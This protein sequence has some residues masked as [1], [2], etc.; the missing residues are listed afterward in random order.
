M[1]LFE[2]YGEEYPIMPCNSIGTHPGGIAF[3]L[4]S[5]SGVSKVWSSGAQKI[6]CGAQQFSFGAVR[7]DIV[8]RWHYHIISN[9]KHLE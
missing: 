9:N 2:E 3:C 6:G 1:F 5:H 4:L 8:T 7:L